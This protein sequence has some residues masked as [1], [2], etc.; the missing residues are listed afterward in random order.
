MTRYLP[1]G[2]GKSWAPSTRHE[3]S[4]SA[5][6][7]PAAAHVIRVRFCEVGNLGS[8]ADPLV[9]CEYRV[10]LVRHLIELLASVVVLIGLLIIL[11]CGG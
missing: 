4:L 9:N 10:T 3:V 2:L 1:L 6:L 5:I 7:Q 11:R 8:S